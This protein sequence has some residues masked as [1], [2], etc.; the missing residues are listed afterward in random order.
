MSSTRPKPKLPLL[1]FE[2]KSQP[3]LGLGASDA[4]TSRLA[5][6]SSQ[7]LDSSSVDHPDWWGTGGT[8]STSGAE[9]SSTRATGKKK[10]WTA[11]IPTFF[12]LFM[13]LAPHVSIF[14]VLFH[15][16]LLGEFGSRFKFLIHLGVTYT[17]SFISLTCFLVVIVRDPGPVD[18]VK[19]Q[20]LED[21]LNGAGNSQFGPGDDDEAEMDDF[22]EGGE[23]ISLTDALMRKGGMGD[24]KQNGKWAGNRTGERRWCQKC[25]SPKP[26]RCHHCSECGRCVLKMDHHCPWLASKCIGHRTYASFVHLLLSVTLLCLYSF[27]LTIRPIQ[28]YLSMSTTVLE[29]D[30]TPYHTLFVALLGL[31]FGLSIGGFWGWHMYLIS[32]NQTTLESLTPYL[33]LGHIPPPSSRPTDIVAANPLLSDTHGRSSS[34]SSSSGASFITP[35]SPSQGSSTHDTPPSTPP[36]RTNRESHDSNSPFYFPSPPPAQLTR[37]DSSDSTLL[38]NNTV[39]RLQEHQLSGMQRRKVR[40]AARKILLY[41]LGSFRRNWGAVT[42]GGRRGSGKGRRSWTW[43]IRLVFCGGRGEGDGYSFDFN[44]RAERQLQRLADQLA[45]M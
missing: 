31:C 4:A 37:T 22:D 5:S 8:G 45:E 24:G 27:F 32:T 14:K 44:P 12:T 1:S 42:L 10:P 28:Y 3:T 40:Y 34:P 43:W 33:L 23:S 17:L 35:K 29:T 9:L 18:G 30:T 25:W 41:D 6:T 26:E 15:F 20:K 39:A 2:L 36:P 13:L 16:Y 11:Y 21:A 7:R 38:N 19:A